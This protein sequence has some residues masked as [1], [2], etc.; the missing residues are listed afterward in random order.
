MWKHALLAVSAA[1]LAACAS[2]PTVYGPASKAGIG[3]VDSQIENNRF[4]VVFE[5]GADASRTQ[6]ESL[7]LRRAAEIAR[8]NGFDWFETVY[9]QTSLLGDQGGGAS[10]G[11]GASGGSRGNVGVGLGIGIDLTPDRSRYSTSL[12]VIMGNAPSPDRPNVYDVDA[13][14]SS[15]RIPRT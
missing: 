12:E 9:L 4:K 1:C 8:N 6:V 10:V 5:G 3:Y 13:V 11:I 7:A 15:T 14:L 2:G